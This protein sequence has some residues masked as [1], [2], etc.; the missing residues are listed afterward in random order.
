MSFFSN[1]HGAEQEQNAQGDFWTNVPEAGDMMP[2][3]LPGEERQQQTGSNEFEEETEQPPQYGQQ[4]N[5]R[6]GQTAQTGE[7]GETEQN[8]Q[9]T[10]SAENAEDTVDEIANPAHQASRQDP[11][12]SWTGVPDP[13]TE[14]VPTQDQDDL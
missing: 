3:T 6:Y 1:P 10:Q 5:T 9:S 2:G 11:L 4:Q 12:G 8:A 14:E 7:T 13:D